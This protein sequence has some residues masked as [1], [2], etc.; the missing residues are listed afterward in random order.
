MVRCDEMLVNEMKTVLHQLR[1]IE[2]HSESFQSNS[3]R[4]IYDYSLNAT[5]HKI[6]WLIDDW[7]RKFHPNSE[8]QWWT[9]AI[10]SQFGI[11]IGPKWGTICWV[12]LH[13]QLDPFEFT[14][15]F[16]YFSLASLALKLII[17]CSELCNMERNPTA[18]EFWNNQSLLPKC[19][20]WI[21]DNTTRCTAN[22]Q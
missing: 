22:P 9:F 7:W 2:F 6:S 16:R 17:Y 3:L 1:W 21:N 4:F 14:E 10:H 19:F 5:S 20:H 13:S 8:F 11:S 15:D 12:V 18:Y